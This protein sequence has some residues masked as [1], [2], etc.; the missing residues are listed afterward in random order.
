[1]VNISLLIRIK[2]LQLYTLN[3]IILKINLSN[4]FMKFTEYVITE[5]I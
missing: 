3:I 4:T 2:I 1:M 5:K